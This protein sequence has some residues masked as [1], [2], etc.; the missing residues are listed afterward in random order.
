[1]TPSAQRRHH[2]SFVRDG[3]QAK[4][5]QS[6]LGSWE[7]MAYIVATIKTATLDSKPTNAM[8]TATNLACGAWLAVPLTKGAC[9]HPNLRLSSWS[10]AS[11]LLRPHGR[12]ANPPAERQ[13]L[14]APGTGVTCLEVPNKPK[15]GLAFPTLTRSF[16]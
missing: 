14:K 13:V 4:L 9:C 15:T 3:S 1:M 12:G 11:V 5:I 6:A 16:D 8:S 10:A 7:L 2:L